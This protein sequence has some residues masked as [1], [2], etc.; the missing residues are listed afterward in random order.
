M[1]ETRIE[2]FITMSF[3]AVIFFS[4]L[5]F[6]GRSMEFQRSCEMKCSGSSA[7]TPFVDGTETC[8]CDIGSGTWRQVDVGE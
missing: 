4:I 6:A 3:F 2:W 8:F 1:R 7:I 5:A